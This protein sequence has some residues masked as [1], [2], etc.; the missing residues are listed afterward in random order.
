MSNSVSVDYT[1]IQVALE[2]TIHSLLQLFWGCRFGVFQPS[3][4]DI[5]FTGTFVPEKI[6]NQTFIAIHVHKILMFVY[7]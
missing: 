7:F 4:L 6:Y 3:A 2:D 1:C 5:S